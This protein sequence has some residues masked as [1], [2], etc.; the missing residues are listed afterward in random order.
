MSS[1]TDTSGADVVNRNY[2][3]NKLG[4]RLQGVWR[5]E[6]QN[7][8]ATA[9]VGALVHTT[10][11]AVRRMGWDHV[12]G[13]KEE[14]LYSFTS[15]LKMDLSAWQSRMHGM[16]VSETPKTCRMVAATARIWAPVTN[17]CLACP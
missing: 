1:S 9:V 7:S 4:F 14:S 11:R 16:S 6:E 17:M 12:G 5:A 10:C 13:G 2:K 8:N 3:E 15:L